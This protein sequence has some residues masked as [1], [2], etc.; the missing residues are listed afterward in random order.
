M[1]GIINLFVAVLS[2]SLFAV[3][4][5]NGTRDI[6]IYFLPL[7]GISHLEL[8]TIKRKKKDTT[9]EKLQ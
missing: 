5:L 6:G 8:W 4:F 9:T 1:E 7:L 2:L 3:A